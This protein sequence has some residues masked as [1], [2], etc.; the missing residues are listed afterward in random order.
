VRE[1]QAYTTEREEMMQIVQLCFNEYPMDKLDGIW[2]CLFNNFR[3]IMA[4]D[5]GNQYLKAHNGGRLRRLNTGTS[6]DLTV[7]MEDYLRCRDLCNV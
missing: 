3:S 1:I 2:G 6:V 7:N 5:G 4:C